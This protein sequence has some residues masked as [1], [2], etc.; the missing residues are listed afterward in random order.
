MGNGV[1]TEDGLAQRLANAKKIMNKVDT[2]DYQKGQI[3]EDILMSD[4]MELIEQPMTEI[5]QPRQNTGQPSIERINQS[6]L[7]DE[8]KRVMIE[9]PI[10]Q[11]EI[12]LNE[13]M[14]IKF[15]EKARKLMEQDG[16]LP[17]KQSQVKQRQQPQQQSTNNNVNINEMMLQLTPIIENTIRKV[18]DE[19]LTQILTA[20]DTASLNE[21]LVLKVGDSIFKGKIT[22]VKSAK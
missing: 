17:T 15:V 7:P 10:V 20:K 13:S 9:R 14:D 21:N 4:P 6:R 8:I 5:K 3:N 22:G 2:G 18:L 11:P 1:I 16:T 19:K 12:S